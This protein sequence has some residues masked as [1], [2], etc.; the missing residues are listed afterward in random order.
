METLGGHVFR[1]NRIEIED[2]YYE[3]AA[4]RGPRG[5][6]R[7]AGGTQEGLGRAEGQTRG[8]GR[9]GTPQAPGHTEPAQSPHRIGEAGG[10]RQDRILAAAVDN[11]AGRAEATP[12]EASCRHPRRLPRALGQAPSGVGADEVRAPLSARNAGSL[13]GAHNAVREPRPP[14]IPS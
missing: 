9:G 6:R 2:A 3:R 8:E 5:V 4:R 1:R 14:I 7:A 12:R 11:R 13:H 10:R